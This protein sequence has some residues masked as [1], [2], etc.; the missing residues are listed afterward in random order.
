MD[1][2]G[3][4][5]IERAAEGGGTGVVALCKKWVKS[6]NA[7][8]KQSRKTSGRVPR[9]EPVVGKYPRIKLAGFN[10]YFS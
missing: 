8:K 9:V 1:V 3:V 10:V 2:D 4:D 7:G 5:G 6:R